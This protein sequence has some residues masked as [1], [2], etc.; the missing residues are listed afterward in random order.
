MS[1]NGKVRLATEDDLDSISRIYNHYVGV[2]TCTFQM[3]PETLEDR[4]RWFDAHDEKHPVTVFDHDGEVIAWASL[5]VWHA[6]E[7]YD[8]TAEVSFY[9]HHDWHRNGI[10]RRLLAD[11]IERARGLGHHVLIGGACTEMTASIKL[12]EAFGFKQAA[13]Y[14][15]IGYKFDRWLDVVYLQLILE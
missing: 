7:A 10:G 13:H 11:L 8:N 4:R 6:R 5:S 3:S 1:I 15:E 9:V 12:Q 2:S 14:K